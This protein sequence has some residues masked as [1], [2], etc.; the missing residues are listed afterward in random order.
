MS[1]IRGMLSMI[2]GAKLT[3][4]IGVMDSLYSELSTPSAAL[5]NR[6]RFLDHDSSHSIAFSVRQAILSPPGTV[7]LAEF[8][9]KKNTYT[10]ITAAKATKVI[11]PRKR[12]GVIIQDPEEITT[13][14]TV[15]RKVQAKDK[16]ND[17][18]IEEPKPLKRQAQIK[19]DEEVARQLEAE[20]NGDINWNSVIKQVKRSERLTDAVMKYQA[21]KRKHLTEAQAKKN[22]VV[23]LKNIAGYKMD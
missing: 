10:P 8:C 7:N 1:I 17:I 5:P 11:A 15:Q 12:R 18:L 3:V 22:M 21:L 19:L 6:S 2:L 13:T 9:H 14:I 20:L 23:Y 16:G 4:P